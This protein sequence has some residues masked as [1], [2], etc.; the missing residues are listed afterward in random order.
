[1]S[2]IKSSGA[3]YAHTS[4]NKIGYTVEGAGRGHSR[5][6][7]HESQQDKEEVRYISCELESELAGNVGDYILDFRAEHFKTV[8]LFRIGWEAKP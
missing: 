4:K 3:G 1:M 5:Y 7:Q 8:T 6:R 2:K